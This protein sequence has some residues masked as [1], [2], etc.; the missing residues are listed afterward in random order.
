MTKYY[1]C[2]CCKHIFEEDEIETVNDNSGASDGKIDLCPECHVPES[3]SS[4]PDL[5][6]NF[7]R[8]EEDRLD[9]M[10][11]ARYSED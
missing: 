4:I 3:F 5:D 6:W 2:D 1:K 11:E 9:S 7:E 10:F 8:R